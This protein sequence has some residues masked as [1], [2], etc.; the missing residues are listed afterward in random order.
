MIFV[1][2]KGFLEISVPILPN[3]KWQFFKYWSVRATIL[4]FVVSSAQALWYGDVDPRQKL[5]DSFFA[6]HPQLRAVGM[7]WQPGCSA[8]HFAQNYIITAGH[9]FAKDV[10]PIDIIFRPAFTGSLDANNLNSRPSIRG[11]RLVFGT[12]GEMDYNAGSDWA[13]VE[14]DPKTYTPG[15]HSLNPSAP[16]F[17]ATFAGW[18]TINVHS[19]PNPIP[20]GGMNVTHIGYSGDFL[21]SNLSGHFEDCHIKADLSTLWGSLDYGLL[22]SDCSR[23]G[24]ASGGPLLVDAY[25]SP[26]IVGTIGGGVAPELSAKAWTKENTNR[27]VGTNA[28]AFVPP[29]ATGFT[30]TW[31]GTGT[32]RGFASGD[33]YFNNVSATNLLSA[34]GVL[35]GD[36]WR[37]FRSSNMFTKDAIVFGRLTSTATID[38]HAWVFAQTKTGIWNRFE[39]SPGDWSDWLRWDLETGMT[40][41]TRDLEAQAAGSTAIQLYIIR[42]SGDIYSRRKLKT[43]DSAWFETKLHEKVSDALRI[44]ASSTG[45]YQQLFVTGRTRI[46]TSWEI[47]SPSSNSWTSFSDFGEGLPKLAMLDVAAGINS[48][49]AMVVYLLAKEAG[50][51]RVFQRT[52]TSATPG[53]AWGPWI[54][55][56]SEPALD[57]ATQIETMAQSASTGFQPRLVIIR[58]GALY[59][60]TYKT[61][62]W[63]PFY[64]APVTAKTP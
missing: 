20:S 53:A 2:D 18:P 27:E 23:N 31:D 35:P 37:D 50:I 25:T 1:K 19:T 11:K 63:V 61:G 60:K 62:A 6:T 24:G 9:C 43:W 39:K 29:N 56:N 38:G 30:A 4:L 52:K 10:K 34:N 28:W 14:L 42:T 32:I 58:N 15:D 64:I 17:P 59:T 7:L 22:A 45:G 21:N 16:T 51:T 8:T 49:G 44:A 36:Q 57:G 13:I 54:V 26:A 48:N 33:V 41:D 40:G 55:W 12:G 5:E 46:K 47:N 3:Q